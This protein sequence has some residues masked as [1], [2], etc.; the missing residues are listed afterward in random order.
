MTTTPRGI[1]VAINPSAA[2]GRGSAV[3]AQVVSALRTAGLEVTALSEPSFDALVAAT[4][5]ALDLGTSALV[6]VGGDGMVNL[7]ANLL[8]G[9]SIPLGIVP[10]GTGNDTARGL[11]IPLDDTDAAIAV[12]LDA[13]TRPPR[14]ID[15]ARVGAP[16][17]P[18]RWFV[19]VLAAGFDAVVNER[20]NL[21]RW[22]RGRSRYTLALLRELA[23]LR[24]RRYRLVLDGVESQTDAMLVSVGNN[25]SLGGGMLVTPNALL[26]DGLLDVLVVQ[27]LSRLAFLRIFPRVFKGTHLTDPRVAVHRARTVS[28]D[29]EGLVAYADGERIGPLPLEVEVV[30]GALRVLAP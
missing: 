24:P 16:G 3:G 22:P 19:G 21:M 29:S 18:Q 20:A 27:P 9:S 5:H 7:G 30:P 1:V 14:V 13:L 4:R 17:G 25:T 8:A 10:S 26:D 12:L 11:G 2:F 23:V 28:I 6:M 15:A